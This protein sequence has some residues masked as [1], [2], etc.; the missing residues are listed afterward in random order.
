MAVTGHSG[1]EAADSRGGAGTSACAA[2][3]VDMPRTLLR[4]CRA[5]HTTEYCTPDSM[6]HIPTGAS[7]TPGEPDDKAY[8]TLKE[9]EDAG[10]KVADFTKHAASDLTKKVSGCRSRLSVA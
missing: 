3:N 7:R 1:L 2:P 5:S 9:I 10:H 4:C 6:A 8:S